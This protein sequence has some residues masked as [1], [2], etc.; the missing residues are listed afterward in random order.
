M[1][2]FLT[3]NLNWILPVVAVLVFAVLAIRT[4]RKAKKIDAEG[5]E[6]DGVISRIEET[7]SAEDATSSYTTYVEYTDDQGQLR[8]SPISLTVRV[9]HRVGDAVRIRFLPGDYKLVREA[10]PRE[11]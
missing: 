5:L 8:E 11:L 9:E 4:L 10:K 2:E 3:Q 7:S 1:Q 6:T